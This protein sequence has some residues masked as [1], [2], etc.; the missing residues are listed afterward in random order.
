MKNM[1]EHQGCPSKTRLSSSETSSGT[2]GSL[3]L[4]KENVKCSTG[5]M[6][7]TI[8]KIVDMLDMRGC[9]G[10]REL[11]LLVVRS[12]VP[13]DAEERQENHRKNH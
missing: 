4:E 8:M 9:K 6:R 1:T 7:Q 12:A 11:Y 2:Q 13:P 5:K 3:S 10:V